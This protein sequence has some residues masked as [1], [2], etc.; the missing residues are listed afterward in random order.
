[1]I[2]HEADQAT[3]M[4]HWQ[5]YLFFRQLYVG[6]K[7]MDAASG[8]GYGLGYAA[9]FALEAK[10]VEIDHSAVRHANK[11]YPH[12]TFIQADVV[13]ADYSEA[14]V[15]TSFE[16]IEHL[17]D[18]GRFLDSLATCQGVIII[19]T[20][21]RHLHSPGNRLTDKP[22]NKFH[23]IEWEPEE[24]AEL[25]ES[26]F[27][28]R[29]IQYLSQY[30]KWP[31]RIEEGLDPSAMYTIAV[32]GDVDLPQWPTVGLSMPTCSQTNQ[33]MEA[34]YTFG[35]YYPG[36][37]EVCA[38]LNGT[39]PE[40]A[41]KLK[42]LAN[43]LDGCLHIIENNENLGYGR[44][45]NIG[46]DYLLRQGKFDLIGVTNDDVIPSVDMMAQLVVAYQELKKGGQ[47]PGLVAPVSNSVAGCQQVNIGAYGDLSMMS[48]NAELWHRAHHSTASPAVQIRGLFFLA[49]P[50]C[51]L[52]IG[53]FD[54]RFGLGNFEDDDLNVRV[55]L[56]GYTLWIAD[57]AFL[58][59][60]GSSTFKSLGLDYQMNMERNL[61]LFCEKWSVAEFH[62]AFALS[63]VPA[64]VHLFVPFDAAPASS[65]A[66]IKL[67]GEEVD[68]V[69]QA[70]DIE[71]AAWLVGKLQGSPRT[72]RYALVE[73]VEKLVA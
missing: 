1:M 17:P 21:S 11:R 33:A 36:R 47:N 23:T 29:R 9:N 64:G 3:E 19:S 12:A 6:K 56:A 62:Q 28:G 49:D 38:V 53:G 7:V 30:A 57:G 68:I 58:H 15:V 4:F 27:Q 41:A 61:R 66:K 5:R 43:D 31:G 40:N 67:G 8:E 51:L 20:P 55:K 14:E 24:F 2:P 32:I 37:I 42:N 34:I 69:H 70:T 46:F 65:G 10:G 73:A 72:A 16:T 26:K 22:L 18:P 63:S 48:Y 39:S 45:A 71:L 54:P 35:R 60:E 59:H 13:E 44:G 50:Q 25:I 52:T